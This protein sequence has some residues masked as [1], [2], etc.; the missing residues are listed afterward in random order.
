[1]SFKIGQKVII[2]KKSV[3]ISLG[4]CNHYKEQQNGKPVFI[5]DIR[6]D[7]SD[8]NEKGFLYVLNVNKNSPYGSNYIKEDFILDV[9]SIIEVDDED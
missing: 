5:V 4:N 1:M 2:R 3:G 9:P 7:W 6:G 8:F